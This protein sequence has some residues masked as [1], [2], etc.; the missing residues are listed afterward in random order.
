MHVPRNAQ[1]LLLVVLC[2]LS[3]EWDTDKPLCML[4]PAAAADWAFVQRAKPNRVEFPKEP[5]ETLSP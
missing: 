5:G 1:L 2:T 4:L 3:P